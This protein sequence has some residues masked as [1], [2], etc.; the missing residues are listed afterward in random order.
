[1][2]HSASP[3]CRLEARGNSVFR[4]AWWSSHPIDTGT[5]RLCFFIHLCLPLYMASLSHRSYDGWASQVAVVVKTPP[6]NAG[7]IRDT[8]SIP[9]LGRSL[10][11]GHSNPLQHSCRENPIDREDWRATIQRIAKSQTQSKWLSMHIWWLRLLSTFITLGE[12]GGKRLAFS[13]SQERKTNKQKITEFS[14][15]GS[16]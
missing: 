6:A 11:G 15:I 7:D 1:M 5:I 13:L 12:T 9:W 4:I 14:L 8:G 3:I 2:V 10:R 16:Y